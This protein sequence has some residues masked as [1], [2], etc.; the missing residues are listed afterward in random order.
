MCPCY[1]Y[2][3]NNNR[4]TQFRCSLFDYNKVYALDGNEGIYE[5]MV[6]SKNLKLTIK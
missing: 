3:I 2:N 6:L 4:A 1:Y 5:A